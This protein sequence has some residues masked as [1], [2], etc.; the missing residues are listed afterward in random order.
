MFKKISLNQMFWVYFVLIILVS[1]FDL[2]IKQKYNNYL[3]FHYCF[4]HFIRQTD[5]YIAYP[6][7]YFDLFKYSPLFPIFM[8]PFV[9]IPI[10]IGAIVWNLLNSFAVFY[11]ITIQKISNTQ[12]TSCLLIVLPEVINNAHNFQSNGLIAGGALFSFSLILK[13]RYSIANII[14]QFLLILKIYGFFFAY[15]FIFAKP[16]ELLKQIGL[17]ILISATTIGLAISFTQFAFIRE[18]FI[19]FYHLL[20]Y[21]STGYGTSFMGVLNLFFPDQINTH[22]IQAIGFFFFITLMSFIRFKKPT[23]ENKYALFILALVFIIVFN[24][25]AESPTMIIGSVGIG[26]YLVLYKQ[27]VILKNWIFWMK[28]IG[29]S[30]LQTD[31]IPKAIRKAYI[32][33]YHL[34]VIP[35]IVFFFFFYVLILKKNFEKL[36][37]K[38]SE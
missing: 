26:L 30:L 5:L 13:N 12:K 19:S 33:P 34:K 18:Q 36:P 27:G 2:F 6:R 35:F 28:M 24:H 7:Q 22:L 32:Y 38:S 31:I 16:K 20:S 21:E 10:Q 23:L 3:I 9:F 11:G 25:R 8:A 29:V 37:L 15:Q 14:L 17:F 1:I 4:E